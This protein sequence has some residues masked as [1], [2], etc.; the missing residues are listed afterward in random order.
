MSPDLQVFGLK[1]ILSNIL[2]CLVAC[3]AAMHR[4]PYW[5]GAWWYAVN[6]SRKKNKKLQKLR[7]LRSPDSGVSQ[8]QV[9]NSK[10]Q[11][12]TA[13]NCKKLQKIAV[14]FLRVPLGVGDTVSRKF[15]AMRRGLKRSDFR[16][17]HLEMQIRIFNWS[18]TDASPSLS[19]SILPGQ[20]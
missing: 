2:P 7:K 6:G 19:G 13:K 1:V 18:T 4:K 15:L 10:K 8:Q 11:Q 5:E 9:K 12:E 3:L 17:I 14:S 20:A 16:P